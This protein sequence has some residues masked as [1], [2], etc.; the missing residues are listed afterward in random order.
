MYSPYRGRSQTKRQRS[1]RKQKLSDA[2]REKR[3]QQKRIAKTF[4]SWKHF[5]PCYAKK[6]QRLPSPLGEGAFST[7]TTLNTLG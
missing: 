3:N 7:L 4:P 6:I 5:L 1:H 2:E